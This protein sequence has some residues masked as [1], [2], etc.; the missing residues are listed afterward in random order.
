MNNG[1]NGS[2]SLLLNCF[3]LPYLK[4]DNCKRYIIIISTLFIIPNLDNI[5]WE[6]LK[7]FSISFV[8]FQLKIHSLFEK[9]RPEELRQILSSLS[10]EERIQVLT[11]CTKDD[12]DQVK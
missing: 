8:H 2:K 7:L 3:N 5:L 4:F 1:I 11:T 12:K 10:E 9:G 6:A